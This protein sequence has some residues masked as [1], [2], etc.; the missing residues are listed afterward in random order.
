MVAGPSHPRTLPGSFLSPG[1]CCH[2]NLAL[3]YILR[4]CFELPG[5]ET[6]ERSSFRAKRVLNGA[7]DEDPILVVP[8]TGVG[9]VVGSPP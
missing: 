9:C 5:C 4:V 7:S 1:L 8:A 3:I 2:P 6:K